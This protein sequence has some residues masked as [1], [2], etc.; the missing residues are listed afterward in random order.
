VNF[1]DVKDTLSFP[2]LWWGL[3][4]ADKDIRGSFCPG[5]AERIARLLDM[6]K[7]GRIDP[8]KMISHK[9]AGFDKLPEAFD[10]M[11]KKTPDLIK[12]IV[13]MQ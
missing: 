6:I 1:F 10:L 12:P 9:F 5:G 13:Y 11:D 8:T 3:G 7:Y 2:A 4:M